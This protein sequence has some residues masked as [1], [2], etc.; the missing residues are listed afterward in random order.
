M[1]G[2]ASNGSF[3]GI[4]QTPKMRPLNGR[5]KWR[6]DQCDLIEHERAQNQEGGG[7]YLGDIS[8][9]VGRIGEFTG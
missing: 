8:S 4:E 1:G 9:S 3:A 6:E 5:E 2:I 7:Q